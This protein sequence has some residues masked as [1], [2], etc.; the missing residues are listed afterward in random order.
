MDKRPDAHPSGGRVNPASRGALRSG[1]PLPLVGREEEM[2]RLGAALDLAAEGRGG[3]IFLTGEPGIG[4]TR[5]AREALAL[6]KDRGF[7]TLEGRA[8]SIEVGLAYA[9]FLDAF[10]QIL[11]G[12]HPVHLAAL[13]DGLP[14][15]GRLF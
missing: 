6:A 13:V 2:S 9:P 3:T 8:Y 4:K 1:A 15:L 12:L 11:R 10:G 7:T 14:D 5:L